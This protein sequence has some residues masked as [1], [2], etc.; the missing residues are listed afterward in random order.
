MSRLGIREGDIEETFTRA[1]GAGGQ[2]VNKTS[3]CVVLVHKPTGVT[4]RCQK[5]RS[6]GLNRFMARR[7][8]ADRIEGIQLGKK[9]EEKKRIEKIKRQKRKRSKRAKEKMLDN[10]TKAG[11]KKTLRKKVHPGGSE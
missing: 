6:Q 9:S 4:V 8:L 2:H 5:A 11:E 3:T 1:R 10:K 7:T